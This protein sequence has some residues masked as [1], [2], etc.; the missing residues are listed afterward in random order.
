MSGLKTHLIPIS[1]RRGEKHASLASSYWI[2]DCHRGVCD[3]H[4]IVGCVTGRLGVAT[5]WSPL[6]S[7]YGLY[8]TD[9]C[10]NVS[11]T[12]GWMRSGLCKYWWPMPWWTLRRHHSEQS[13]LATHSL[14]SG[15][16]LC[17]ETGVHL[18]KDIVYVPKS[19]GWW[20]VQRWCWRYTDTRWLW[21]DHQLCVVIKDRRYL[22]RE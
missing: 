3:N 9:G 16:L 15:N 4:T 20:C 2:C 22:D 6:L 18:Q 10:R 17:G 19:A 5:W 14:D 12:T 21:N 11:K 13:M 8:R 7:G 1:A